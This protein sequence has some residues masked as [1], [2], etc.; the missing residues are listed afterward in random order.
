MNKNTKRFMIISCT[1][2]PKKA[3]S[4]QL[5]HCF[6]LLKSDSLGYTYNFLALS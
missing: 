3:E 4:N 2:E 5:N 6:S 1:P